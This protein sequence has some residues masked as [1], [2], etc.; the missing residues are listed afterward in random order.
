MERLFNLDAQLVFDVLINALN[1]FVLFLFLSYMFSNPLRK[2]LRERKE[3]IKNQ[4][5]DAAREKADA[6]KLKS[7]YQAKLDDVQKEAEV[8]LQEARKKAVANERQIVQGAQ[9][10]AVRIRQRANAEIQLE[11][12]KAEDDMKKQIVLVATQMA[13]KVVGASVD[14]DRQEEL[15]QQTL[16][17]MGDNVWQN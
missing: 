16:K 7:E 2:L 5:D 11:K 8:M 6:E 4:L 12:E 13:G 3:K 17:E 9:E 14:E 15:I 1:I 10:E